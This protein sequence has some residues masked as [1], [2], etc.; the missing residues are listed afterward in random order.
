MSNQI[1]FLTNQKMN[2]ESQTSLNVVTIGIHGVVCSKMEEVFN[3]QIVIY[4]EKYDVS[5]LKCPKK[6]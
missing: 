3:N 4:L 2:K 1:V 6:K 5:V